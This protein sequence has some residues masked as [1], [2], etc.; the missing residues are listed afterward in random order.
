MSTWAQTH[1][2]ALGEMHM[3]K[4]HDVARDVLKIYR[5]LQSADRPLAAKELSAA[6]YLSKNQ[7]EHRLD[8]LI[9]NGNVRRRE[10]GPDGR[11]SY[12]EAMDRVHYCNGTYW[13]PKPL[14]EV[15]NG[16]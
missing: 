8:H 7:V 11:V 6:I 13:E 5:E 16:D 2:D 10:D 4:Y 15:N 12:Y 9:V 14:R 3:K 1:T